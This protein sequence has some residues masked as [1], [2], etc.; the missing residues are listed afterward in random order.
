VFYWFDGYGI[1]VSH[2][3]PVIT[4]DIAVPIGFPVKIE[5]VYGHV[6]V[7]DHIGKVEV[8][9]KFP[10][11]ETGT[12]LPFNFDCGIVDILSVDLE[13]ARINV[14]SVQT[15]VDLMLSDS[16]MCINK[17]ES[18]CDNPKKLD[19]FQASLKGCSAIDCYHA[20]KQATLHIDKGSR[21]HLGGVDKDWKKTGEGEVTI[22]GWRVFGPDEDD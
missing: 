8:I 22:R 10:T 6:T 1:F 4:I 13:K 14:K 12:R 7:S 21:L 5:Q 11:D 20:A 9:N 15:S 19:S 2:D 17:D 18:S 3:E 16:Y